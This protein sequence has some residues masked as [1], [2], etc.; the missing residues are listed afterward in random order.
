MDRRLNSGFLKQVFSLMF[1]T[2]LTAHG[3]WTELNSYRLIITQSRSVPKMQIVSFNTVLHILFLHL[4]KNLWIGQ[5][6]C[7][8]KMAI[9]AWIIALRWVQSL[10]TDYKQGEE[11]N[12]FKSQSLAYY[13]S[14]LLQSFLEI[15]NKHIFFS[16]L[17]LGV[18]VAR[19][20]FHLMST[21]QAW[22]AVVNFKYHHILIW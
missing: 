11:K 22:P 14:Y 6:Y 9:H 1:E 13:V 20:K 18:S 4:D 2:P 12:Q 15:G 10:V 16:P 8:Y 21:S 19:Q 3:P 7:N 17:F 5:P